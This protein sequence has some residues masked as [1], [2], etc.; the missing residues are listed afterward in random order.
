MSHRGEMKMLTEDAHEINDELTDANAAH[1]CSQ[2]FVMSNM[3][4]A[5]RARPRGSQ[6]GDFLLFLLAS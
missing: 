5:W 6:V 1:N 2:R 4:T 3:L